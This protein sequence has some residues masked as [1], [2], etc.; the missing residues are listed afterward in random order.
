MARVV[1]KFGGSSLADL[2]RLGQVA[3]LVMATRRAGHDLCVVVSAMGKTTDGLLE[4][5]RGAARSA[6]ANASAEPPRRELD[7][8]VS[9]GER[10]SMA[11]LSIAIRARGGDAVSLT[12]S[13]SGIMTNDRH[14]DARILEVRPFRIA[15]APV[16]QAEFRAFVEDGGYARREL[17]TAEGWDWRVRSAAQHPVYWK[18]E[19]SAWLRRHYDR[20]VALEDHL[21]MC[22]VNAYEA[23]A[24]CRWAKRRL[25][26]EA[27]WELAAGRARHPWGDEPPTCERAELDLCSDGPC[28]VGA[29]AGGDSPHG[30]R[31][32]T[33]N[34]WEWTATPFGAYPDFEPGPY[35]EYSQPWFGS[36]KVLRGASFATRGRMRHPK[37]RHFL[38]PE[39]DDVFCGFRSCAA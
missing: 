12:G 8:L 26:T 9:T 23:E 28:E 17:W 34:V 33:G 6:D 13:Q 35:A 20:W 4:L 32:M 19:G 27:E 29:H 1:Q 15:R 36:H 39:R 5:A 10:V 24:Y 30:L 14:F 37:Y 3:D 16:T 21:P 7:M 38:L 22:F 18:R 25:P 11:L 2:E 31:Q